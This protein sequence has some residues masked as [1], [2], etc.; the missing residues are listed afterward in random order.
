[1]AALVTLTHHVHAS[2]IAAKKGEYGSLIVTIGDLSL[3]IGIDDAR[4]LA[5]DIRNLIAPPDTVCDHCGQR[6]GK[7]DLEAAFWLGPVA[8]HVCDQCNEA[9]VEHATTKAMEDAA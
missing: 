3:F 2:K 4:K 7:I 6:P 9:I 8:E 5:D 1:M